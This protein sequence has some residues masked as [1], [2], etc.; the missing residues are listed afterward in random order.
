[1][2]RIVVATLLAKPLQECINEREKKNHLTVRPPVLIQPSRLSAMLCSLAMM[3]MTSLALM[4]SRDYLW[5]LGILLMMV[6]LFPA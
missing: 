1:M 4:L 2:P 3:L 5:V 6:S